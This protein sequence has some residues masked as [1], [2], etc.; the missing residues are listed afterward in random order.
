MDLGRSKGNTQ[1]LE[2]KVG[3]LRQY[4]FCP[5]VVYFQ[6]VL[7][8]ERK[9]TYKMEKGKAVEEVVQ[10]LEARR[11]L[12]KYGIDAGTRRFGVWLRSS[13]LGLSGKIDMVIETES[14]CFPVDFKWTKGGVQR[15]HVYQLGGYALLLEDQTGKEVKTGFIYLI[16]QGHVATQ[17]ISVEL[18][19]ECMRILEGI[20][21]MIRAERFPEPP[22][23]TNKC[24]EC[25]YQNYCRDVW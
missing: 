24:N 12:K 3:D 8:V 23:K 5:R 1:N 4:L 17:E 19:I 7:P 13:G 9:T 20:R 15:N 11:K 16:A 18:K 14:Q 25:E 22:A 10:R 6:Y 2:L 21:E